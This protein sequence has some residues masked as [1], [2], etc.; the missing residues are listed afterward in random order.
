MNFQELLARFLTGTSVDVDADLY[1]SDVSV[2]EEDLA[3]LR[4]M[5]ETRLAVSYGSSGSG[6][7]FPP[8]VE[9]SLANANSLLANV[10]LKV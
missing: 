7:D 4:A 10:R 5:F 6:L 9:P 8:Y 3:Q 2:T 1:Y